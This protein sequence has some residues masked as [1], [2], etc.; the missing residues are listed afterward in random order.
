MPPARGL[1]GQTQRIAAEIC[2]HFPAP[3]SPRAQSAHRCINPA[4]EDVI[5]SIV[6]GAS[7]FPPRLPPAL[8]RSL[9]GTAPRPAT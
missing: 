5:C 2:P 9:F 4:T 6:A 1:V 7:L 3:R 8:A